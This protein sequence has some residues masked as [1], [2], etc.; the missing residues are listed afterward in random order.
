M[1]E[2]VT[3]STCSVP[4]YHCLPLFRVVDN[5]NNVNIFNPQYFSNKLTRTEKKHHTQ[6][7]HHKSTRNIQTVENSSRRYQS[8][9]LTNLSNRTQHNTTQHINLHHVKKSDW[10]NILP[11]SLP[12]TCD[13][14]SKD[15]MFN[16]LSYLTLESCAIVTWCHTR[17][18]PPI[19]S[20]QIDF[21]P[22]F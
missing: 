22:P 18:T 15:G 9:R 1:M 4:L 6:P 16:D 12:T 8:K 5:A 14:S 17:Y 13:F 2:K 3:G 19:L 11:S 20:K 7:P 10:L 21:K